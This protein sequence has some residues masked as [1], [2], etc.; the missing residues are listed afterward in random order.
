M[1]AA[2]KPCVLIPIYQHGSTI[3]ATVARLRGFAIPIFIVD[4]GSDEATRT[5]L[6]RLAE[7]EPLVRLFHLPVN[8]GKGAAVMHAM[9]Q[10]HAAGFTHGLQVDADGQ[11][12][13][14]DLPQFMAAAQAHPGTVVCGQPIYDATIPK[15]R[16]YGRYL[17]HF[18]VWVET[19]S[20]AIGDSM[21]GFRLYPLAATCELIERVAIPQRM[22]F[23]T[24]IIVRL[25]WAGL[26]VVNL[27]TRVTYPEG[28]ISHFDALR[29]NLRISKMH[30]RLFFG[31]LPRL[32][33]LLLRRGGKPA[34]QT[35]HW[36]RIGERGSLVGMRILLWLYLLLG[37]A[38]VSLLLYP[39]V[40]Y[41]FATSRSAR[42]ASKN[43]LA[44]VDGR[45]PRS[46]R[47]FRHLYAFADSAADKLGAWLGKIK[48]EQVTLVD[49]AQIEALAKSDK[50]ALLV[51]SHLGNLEMCRA[52]ANAAG[53]K[54]VNAV[55][56]SE[57]AARFAELLSDANRD[58]GVNLLHVTQ[59]GPDTAILLKDKIDAGEWVVI[60]GDRTPASENGR[61]VEAEFL[62]QPAPFAQGPWI[63][64]ALLGCPVFLFFCLKEAGRYHLYL[65]PF[66]E[67][68]CLP[69]ASRQTA[70]AECVR[71][72][73]ARLEH[74]ARRAPLQWFNF[75]DFWRGATGR[76]QQQK[77]T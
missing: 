51:G 11:H 39:I 61:V 29:D 67:Q 19:L 23:D 58:Y 21:C 6:Q 54:K 34:A 71:R 26:G 48:H 20:F 36:A 41:F 30:T 4:D 31:M 68:L 18:W 37:P 66:A 55:V 62:G 44:R 15:A 10:A 52:L 46:G 13:L 73:A 64:A 69:R 50:G 74:Y 14:E 32:P 2:F 12:A 72:Y 63:L 22:D 49:P 57:H 42:L 59:F 9:R 17:T 47:V 38:V 27:P 56:Y 35:R 5:V 24:D 76:P 65:E 3:E 8:Q 77:Q 40:A 28:G 60:V 1:S 70:L 33:Q 25:Y 45:T 75:Y 16:L 7:H 43:F 53:L